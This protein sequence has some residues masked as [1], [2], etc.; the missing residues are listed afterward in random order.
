MAAKLQCEICG[1][2][3]IGK[4]GGI[5]E[6]ENCG[7]EYSTEW[8][9]AKI[10]EI[11]GT[12]KVEG[13]VEVTGRVQV[14]NG[15]P[16]AKSLVMRGEQALEDMSWELADSLFSRALEIEPENGEA[17][18]GKY[19]ANRKWNSEETAL[20]DV[21]NLKELDDSA[22]CWKRARK[23]GSRKTQDSISRIE[24]EWQRANWAHRLPGNL[25]NQL[26]IVDGRL[27]KN[28]DARGRLDDIYQVDIPYGVTSIGAKVFYFCRNL[29]KVTIPDTV[30]QIEKE[31]FGHCGLQEIVLPNGL[32]EIQEEAF[33]F[34][35]DLNSIFIPDTVKVI[36]E[37]AFRDCGVREVK[38]PEGLTTI[39]DHTF[40][41]CKQLNEVVIPNS[42]KT[43]G[44]YAFR[45]CSFSEVTLPI[46]LMEIKEEAFAF[47]HNLKKVIIPD[48]VE[49]IGTRAFHNSGIIETALPYGLKELGDEAYSWCKELFT[50]TI[51]GSVK[52]IKKKAFEKCVSLNRVKIENGIEIIDRNAFE[53]CKSLIVISIPDS[54]KTIHA[55][56]FSWC[57]S[58]RTITIPA[59]INSIYGKAFYYCRS[60]YS[61]VVFSKQVIF[62]KDAFESVPSLIISAYPGSTAET[63]AEANGYVF[64]RIDSGEEAQAHMCARKQHIQMLR[65]ET[66]NINYDLK[67]KYKEYNRFMLRSSDP[68]FLA[69]HRLSEIQKELEILVQEENLVANEKDRALRLD[70]LQE[71]KSKL[72][73]DL[74]SVKGAFAKMRKAKI[75]SRLAEIE[76]ELE[77]L[78]SD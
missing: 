43:I 9:K 48:H 19:C 49:S 21:L 75:E 23:F 47:C 27:T 3:L 51:P 6:C 28:P 65:E 12:V 13:T 15:G 62:A 24:S 50:I 57:V 40:S 38:L 31:A 41:G 25:Q 5:F 32:I 70:F 53:G 14:E 56:A 20:K 17:F 72:Q 22:G 55:E 74:E 7:T 34:C 4:P 30:K 44:S 73:A 59:S 35:K 77:K 61:C 52:R 37:G 33:I 29:T 45:N 26:L 63:F 42:V 10:Q 36:G 46:S 8:A 67:T 76:T 68:K 16:N 18:W 71:E 64:K 58:L 11:T 78:E 39:N 66:R 54:V 2:K 1:G 60:L 69:E